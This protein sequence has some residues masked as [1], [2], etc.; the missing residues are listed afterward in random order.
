MNK[1]FFFATAI[2]VGVGCCA[3]FARGE[4]IPMAPDVKMI[5]EK[6]T[7]GDAASE[8]R[9]GLCYGNGNGVEQDY[10]NAFKW[11]LKAANQGDSMAQFNAGVCYYRGEGVAH[12][13]PEALN[14]FSK[15]AA[16]GNV[17]AQTF[18]KK[19]RIES[20]K[21]I[22]CWVA[23]ILAVLVVLI[24]AKCKSCGCSTSSNA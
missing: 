15:A 23:G 9:L 18:L 12:N 16:Q 8:R 24:A 2:A 17:E 11:F 20:F 14:W 3:L 6:A 7:E 19:R 10:T 22:A 21:R 5:M 4:T 1:Q 13:D